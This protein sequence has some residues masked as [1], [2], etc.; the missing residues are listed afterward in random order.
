VHP[1]IGV[2][3]RWKGGPDRADVPAWTLRLK[4]MWEAKLGIESLDV[5]RVC[6][7]LVRDGVDAKLCRLCLQTWHKPCCMGLVI[8]LYI[9]VSHGITP[10]PI[11]SSPL[12]HTPLPFHSSSPTIGVQQCCVSD[13]VMR[14]A[15][16][17]Q[18]TAQSVPR[19]Q[20]HKHY[21][22]QAVMQSG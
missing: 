6:Q 15:S 18:F 12:H 19:S 11:S 17:R 10:T 14:R 9:H 16:D 13:L 20:A 21:N 7:H 1:A 5:C 8:D 2:A 22:S 4:S 3:I